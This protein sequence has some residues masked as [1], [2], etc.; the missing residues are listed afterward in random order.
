MNVILI[1]KYI[2]KVDQISITR[3]LFV[4]LPRVYTETNN[5]KENQH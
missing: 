2:I 4:K 3:L 5:G 1:I